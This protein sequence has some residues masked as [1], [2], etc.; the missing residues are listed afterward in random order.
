MLCGTMASIPQFVAGTRRL[1]AAMPNGDGARLLALESSGTTNTH[2]YETLINRFY[3]MHVLRTK[4]NADVRASFKSLATSPA[5]AIMNG[6]NEITVTGN[7]KSWDR[8]DVLSKIDVPTLLLTGQ[9]DEVSSIVIKRCAPAFAD[10]RCTFCRR[11]RT[12]RCK[13]HPARTIV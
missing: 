1:G 13:N 2:E 3:D 9:Y 10:R 11:A 12:L 7:L 6:P 4:P 8:R 5:Y